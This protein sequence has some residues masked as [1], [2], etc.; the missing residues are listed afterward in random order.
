MP[1]TFSH[2]AIILPLNYL[3]VCKLSQTS[4]II[5][6]LVPDFEYFF[7]MEDRKE[8][9]HTWYGFIYLG[10]P[11]TIVL[12]FLFHNIIRDPLI[13]NMPLA[14]QLRLKVY[15]SFNW[16]KKWKTQWI[17]IIASTFIGGVSHFIWDFFTH[18]NSPLI[19]MFLISKF[20]SMFFGALQLI[21]SLLGIYVII[22]ALW[23]LPKN[24]DA[25]IN[26]DILPYWIQVFLVTISVFLIRISANTSLSL[27]SI[28]V[29][30]IASILIALISISLMSRKRHPINH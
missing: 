24:L 18:A 2:P 4:L 26:H 30:L 5:G 6:S 27:K 17:W 15:T 29:S 10:I 12:A 8:W 7:W 13:N 3:R 23:Q 19:Y 14:L 16:N 25:R 11:L 21:N 1:F 22:F 28:F 20:F 9:L